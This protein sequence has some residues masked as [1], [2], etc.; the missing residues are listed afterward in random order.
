[1]LDEV[2]VIKE[3]TGVIVKDCMWKVTEKLKGEGS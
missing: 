1:M 2:A 3:V